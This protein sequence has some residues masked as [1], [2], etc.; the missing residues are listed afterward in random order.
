MQQNINK[1]TTLVSSLDW[2]TGTNETNMTLGYKQKFSACEVTSTVNSK[3]KIATI[4]S[5]QA[6]FFGLKLCGVANLIKNTY[7]FGFGINIG[8]R[9]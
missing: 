2:N 8:Q 1:T 5:T 6:N 9:H 4:L 7:K 3:A